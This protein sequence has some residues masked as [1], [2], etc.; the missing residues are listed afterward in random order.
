MQE[1]CSEVVASS[2]GVNHIGCCCGACSYV[3]T[4]ILDKAPLWAQTH[5]ADLR[6]RQIS[7]IDPSKNFQGRQADQALFD[8]SCAISI[9]PLDKL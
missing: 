7:L 2:Y 1:A 6:S 9:L 4:Y 5:Y 3:S 8:R